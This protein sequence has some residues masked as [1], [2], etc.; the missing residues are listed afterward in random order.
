MRKSRRETS[1]DAYQIQ[2][3]DLVLI[4]QSSAKMHLCTSL[5][6]YVNRNIPKA[7]RQINLDTA[8]RF[9]DLHP[10]SASLLHLGFKA[11]MPI[12][13]SESEKKQ[14]KET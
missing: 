8:A 3:A 1:S 10:F 13:T 11:V 5:S 4:S 7:R 12:R 9:K 6:A 14:S 2:T